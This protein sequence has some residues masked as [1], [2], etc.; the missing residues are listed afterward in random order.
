[1]TTAFAIKLNI[2]RKPVCGA[3]CNTFTQ[4]IDALAEVLYIVTNVQVKCSQRNIPG[5]TTRQYISAFQLEPDLKAGD[6]VTPSFPTEV[7]DVVLMSWSPSGG[8]VLRGQN[9]VN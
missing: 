4:L 6:I 3:V 2:G 7:K 8:S 1:M 5:N 9:A